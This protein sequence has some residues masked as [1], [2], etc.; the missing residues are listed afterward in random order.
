MRQLRTP[1]FCRRRPAFGLQLS[2][3]AIAMRPVHAVAKSS[4]S[5][6]VAP[7]T[8]S[9]TPSETL[10]EADLQALQERVIDLEG[11]LRVAMGSIQALRGQM[12]EVSGQVSSLL[13]V[14][15]WIGR[16]Y[17]WVRNSARH[18]PWH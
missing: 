7:R 16:V 10:T 5:G 4:G 3:A 15:E 17:A 13:S 18:F 14:A 8:Q 2:L 9:R 6:L 11:G 1:A 12:V